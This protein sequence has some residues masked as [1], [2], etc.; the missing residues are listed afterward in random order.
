MMRNMSFRLAIVFFWSVVIIGSIYFLA[1]YSQK[2]VQNSLNIFIW[3]KTIDFTCIR[4]FQKETG[5]KINTSYYESNEELLGKLENNTDNGYDLILPSDYAVEKMIQKGMLQEIDITRI[6]CFK[7]IDPRLVHNYFDPHNQYSL[8]YFWG[9]Y[10]IIVNKQYYKNVDG[11]D[12]NIPNSLQLVFDPMLIEHSVCMPRNAREIAMLASWY[13]FGDTANICLLDKKEAIKKLL[14]E[15]KP[16]VAAYG[17]EIVEYC[18]LSHSAGAALALTT[19]YLSVRKKIDQLELI[20]PKEGVFAVID[21]FVVP[22]NSE[23][24]ELVYK[25]LNY[26]YQEDNLRHHCEKFGVYSPLKKVQNKTIY[27][28]AVENAQL[29]FFNADSPK[30]L[31]CFDDIWLS[32]MSN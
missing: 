16:F 6:N 8:P 19:D 12:K 2:S 3:S 29:R 1:F 24:K 27:V 25:F 28:S 21:S 10:S 18:L 15:Q 4:K 5:I 31:H 11:T 7:H 17:D 22:K 20:I 23:K 26:L 30:Q 9:V 14:I 13:L 32:L